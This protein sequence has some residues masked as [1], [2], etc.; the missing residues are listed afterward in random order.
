MKN[1]KNIFMILMSALLFASCGDVDEVDFTATTPSDKALIQLINQLPVPPNAGTAG[2]VNY[3]NYNF[4]KI[5]VN[6]VVVSRGTATITEAD[7]SGTSEYVYPLNSWGI[8]PA[9]LRYYEVPAGTVNIKLYR[10]EGDGTEKNRN[11][12]LK[13]DQSITVQAGKQS[14]ILHDFSKPPIVHTEIDNF[15]PER[16]TT[17]TDTV[18]YVKFFNF[19]YESAGVESALK[20]QYQYQYTINPIWTEIDRD[21]G[22]IPEGVSVGAAIP[23]A[24]QKKSAWLNLGAPVGFGENTGWQIVPVK[25]TAFLQ[26]GSAVVQYRVVVAS[27]GTLGVNMV[28]ATDDGANLL[29]CRD[30]RAATDA[31]RG[32]I[33]NRGAGI[34]GATGRWYQHYFGGYRDSGAPGMFIA[35]FIIK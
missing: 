5:E 15:L 20:L 7:P 11:M 26:Q 8:R 13:Y 9:E 2:N 29:L 33:H 23:A 14:L 35:S 16:E 19:M 31:P 32:Y 30:T 25:R 1:L 4:L 22:K 17:Y 28:A 21:K 24:Q 10:D 27:G 34:S 3:L 6:G 18:Q 12:V